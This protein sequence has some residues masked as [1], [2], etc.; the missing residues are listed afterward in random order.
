MGSSVL[1]RINV[2]YEQPLAVLAG[3]PTACFTRHAARGR[4]CRSSRLRHSGQR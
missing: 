2:D 4:V 1:S 3:E